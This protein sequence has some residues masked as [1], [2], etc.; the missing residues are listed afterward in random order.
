MKIENIKR[1]SEIKEELLTFTHNIEQLQDWIKQYPEGEG[2]II[3]Q[4]SDGSGG[5]NIDSMFTNGNYNRSLYKELAD[6]NLTVLKNHYNVL[7][8]EIEEL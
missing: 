6:V 7:I 4:Y 2:F 1:A 5:L 3:Q 8:A